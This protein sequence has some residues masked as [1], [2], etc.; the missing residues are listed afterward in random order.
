MRVQTLTANHVVEANAS[1]AVRFGAHQSGRLSQLQCDPA[2]CAL[3]TA[4]LDCNAIWN[5]CFAAGGS[6]CGAGFWSIACDKGDAC[7]VCNGIWTCLPPGGSCP[8]EFGTGTVA[9][10]G[11]FSPDGGTPGGDAGAGPAGPTGCGIVNVPGGDAAD[12]R[13]FEMGRDAG[14]FV[15]EWNTYGIADQIAV[16]YEDKVIFDTGCVGGAGSPT[17]PYKGASTQI[18][19]SVTPDCKAGASGS[20]WEY[21]VSCPP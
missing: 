12:Q 18:T 14:A 3:G 4:C 2:A 5:G 15:F 11:F 17:I 9:G 13:V 6:C 7:A 8:A 21:A 1:G 19:V 16:S 20:Q 10:D